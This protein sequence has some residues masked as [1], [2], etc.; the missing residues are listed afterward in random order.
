MTSLRKFEWEAIA[1]LL[2]AV[3]AIVLH[4][5]NVSDAN[6]LRVITLSLV[7]LIFLRDLRNEGRWE[8]IE[9]ACERSIEHLEEIRTSTRAAELDLVGPTRLRSAC[10]QFAAR[11]R[12]EVVW[13]NVCPETLETQDLFHAIL[14]PFLVNPGVTTIRFVL[15]HRERE[16]WET[17]VRPMVEAYH[18]HAKVEPPC[19]TAI[20]SD[21]SFVI[22]ETD[23]VDGKAEALLAFRGEPFVEVHG[24]RTVPGYLIH[25][26]D[27]SELIGRLREV[28]RAC[29]LT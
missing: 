6:L 4:Y 13:F 7:S 12:G 20:D 2:A 18:D 22:A 1:G 5:F 17:K 26:R 9:R 28:E 10:A 24:G 8:A 27:N 14:H 25:V 3:T 23:T 21:L 29:R 11:G 19:W 15:D 16:R